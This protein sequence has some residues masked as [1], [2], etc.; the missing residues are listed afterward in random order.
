MRLCPVNS[1]DQQTRDP[2]LTFCNNRQSTRA[3]LPSILIIAAWEGIY[4]IGQ[5][6]EAYFELY[7]NFLKL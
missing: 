7:G 6:L 5:I 1:I 3:Q 4:T 2:S